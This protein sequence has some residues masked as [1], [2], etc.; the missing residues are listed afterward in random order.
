MLHSLHPSS[1]LIEHIFPHS[2]LPQWFLTPLSLYMMLQTNTELL[3]PY[4]SS[5]SPSYLFKV[6]FQ[7]STYKAEL[8]L[9]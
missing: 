1:E 2:F 5:V 7:S 9:V 3:F 4:D 6:P 8:G